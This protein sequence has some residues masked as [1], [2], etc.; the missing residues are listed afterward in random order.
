MSIS[1]SEIMKESNSTTM[2]SMVCRKWCL[3][4]SMS[5]FLVLPC[6]VFGGCCTLLIAGEGLQLCPCSC[7]WS[8]ETSST[9]VLACK[10]PAK[11]IIKE[12]RRK[13]RKRK[14]AHSKKESTFKTPY[15]WWLSPMVTPQ[16]W[17]SWIMYFWAQ[18]CQFE[19]YCIPT[20]W[21]LHVHLFAVSG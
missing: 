19:D 5:F 20:N 15:W 1:F 4:V 21:S 3:C 6:I 16:T 17:N 8:I 7:M 18:L 12:R 14:K 2:Y 10:S 9:R 13:K 11:C